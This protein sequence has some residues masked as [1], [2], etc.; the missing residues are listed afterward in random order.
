MFFSAAA[1]LLSP[2]IQWFKT[3]PCSPNSRADLNCLTGFLQPTPFLQ[4]AGISFAL[5]QNKGF[6]KF[7]ETLG[8][9]V[10]P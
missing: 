8:I 1:F 6:K 9:R 7:D 4:P 2:C 10:Q 3:T 5:T